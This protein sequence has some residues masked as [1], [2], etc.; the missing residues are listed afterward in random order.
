[1]FDFG[2]KHFFRSSN[3]R[4]LMV[5]F[6]CGCQATLAPFSRAIEARRWCLNHAMEWRP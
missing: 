4:H 2:I 3:M 1:M 5:H 6:R